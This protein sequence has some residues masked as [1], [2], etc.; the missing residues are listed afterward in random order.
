METFEKKISKKND[1]H[2]LLFT[3]VELLVV[4]AIIVILAGLLLPTLAKARDRGKQ[5]YCISNLK[6]I[7]N[8]QNMYGNDYNEYISPVTFGLSSVQ[9]FVGNYELNGTMGSAGWGGRIYSY[10]GGGNKKSHC[11]KIYVCPADPRKIDLTDYVSNSTNGTGASYVFCSIAGGA[12]MYGR[13]V[14]NDSGVDVWKKSAEVKWP[15]SSCINSED[16]WDRPS[17]GYS[18]W[19]YTP[20]NAGVVYPPT[21]LKSRNSLFVDGHAASVSM[22]F[23]IMPSDPW[24]F[25]GTAND[26][27]YRFWYSKY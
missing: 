16:N 23:F 12:K 18:G 5:I 21:H 22:L 4:I 17:P 10:M 24:L 9:Q 13:G 27:Y 25:K 1:F 20:W 7:G 6:Q 15:S 8:A 11:W 26:M 19:M 2:S 3:L 14:V